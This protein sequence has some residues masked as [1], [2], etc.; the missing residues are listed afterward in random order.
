M[1]KK[2]LIAT[3]GFLP[4]WD[5]ISSFL[6]ELIPRI[7]KNYDIHIIA[8]NLGSYKFSYKAKIT[9][10]KTIKVRL[11][12]NYY[13]SLVDINKMAREIKKTDLIWVQCMGLIGIWGIILGKIYKKPV[14]LYNHMLEWEVYPTSQGINILKVPI[15]VITK[16]FS[17]ILYNMCKTIIVPS[18]EQ[19]ELLSLMGVKCDKRVV[20][21]GVDVKHY[22]PPISKAQAKHKLGIDPVKFVVGYGGRLSLEKD[23]KTLYRAF[24]RLTKKHHDVILLIAGGGRP[25]L[26]KMFS[27]KENVILTGI[28]DD[29]APYYQAMDVYVLPSLTETT[30]LTT[31]EAMAV[32]V[33]VI[34]TP[35]GFIKEYIND[36][37]NGMLFPKKNSY[38]LYKKIEY[39]IEN[40][41]EKEKL[42][43]KARETIVENYTWDK[44]AK[45]IKEILN[46]S[47]PFKNR[48][49]L[50][51]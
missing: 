14:L 34:A 25:E 43:K 29:L 40:P 39:L 35:V 26:E 7:E 13:S 3:D 23:L 16:T 2:L 31:M 24:I 36:G 21:L 15:N 30:S 12:D 49:N 47:M 50:A 51:K 1:K 33:T 38:T 6:H 17:T 41:D 5:G 32:G 4:R 46:S 44:T 28:Q 45:G 8:P 11:A 37:V 10:F 48:T 27:D 9:R 19:V 18:I 22:K 20:H 42:G